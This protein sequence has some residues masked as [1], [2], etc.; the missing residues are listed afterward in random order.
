MTSI[1]LLIILISLLIFNY[2]WFRKIF[3]P[4]IIFIFFFTLSVLNGVMNTNGWDYYLNWITVGVIGG[5]AFIFTLCSVGV[6]AIL[7]LVRTRTYVI[8][9][10]VEQLSVHQERKR[11]QAI[12]IPLWVYLT[13]LIFLLLTAVLM[14]K[15]VENIVYA[16]G[17]QGNPL[18]ALTEY[19]RLTK[20]EQVDTSVRGILGQMFVASQA[21]SYAWGY[22][23]LRNFFSKERK[24]D[25][26]A[27]I[28]FLVALVIPLTSGAR[29]GLVIVVFATIIYA[30]IF[31]SQEELAFRKK[32]RRKTAI[33]VSAI[34][35]SGVI[36]FRPLVTLMGRDTGT[37]STF[38]YIS[39]YLGAPVKNL[40]MY[41]CDTLPTPIVT[42]SQYW[43]QQ[44]FAIL[45]ESIAHW[46]GNEAVKY[47]NDWQPFQEYNGHGLG[48]VYTTYYP[49]IF[50]WGILGAFIA[51]AVTAILCQ[52]LYSHVVNYSLLPYNTLQL[53]T[54]MYGFVAYGLMMSFYL[55]FLVTNVVSSA[56][57]RI[58]AV[59]VF[60]SV[61]LYFLN[62]V[63]RYPAK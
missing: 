41:L 16:T 20:F 36:L 23:M 24:K 27:L 2:L 9:F 19:T 25:W 45:Y 3:H 29:A 42:H 40:D 62:K 11:A 50:D 1:L 8:P 35:L 51:I 55:N 30:L 54:I 32:Y 6:D 31:F 53:S 4:A 37:M 21:M 48:N 60:I 18:H 43:G 34:A 10:C 5:G 17:Y 28:N 15:R 49:Y 7:Q 57:I 44:T 22:I 12:H 38:D 61:A 14:F 39:F 26:L 46:T 63:Q 52:W 33:V 58:F 59:W 13:S 47:W 56:F